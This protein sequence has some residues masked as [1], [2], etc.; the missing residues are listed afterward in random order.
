MGFLSD[1]LGIDDAKDSL[2]DAN[3][4]ARDA[5]DKGIS[6]ADAATQQYGQQSLDYLKPAIQGG[7]DALS[8]IRAA[9]GL[10]GI[11]AQKAFYT[12]FQTDPGF[13]AT[14]QAGINAIQRSRAASGNLNSG[15]TMKSLFNFGQRSLSDQFRQRLQ[16]LNGISTQG[17]AARTNSANITGDMGRTFAD[18]RM[19]RGQ[20]YGDS[21]LQEGKIR[22]DASVAVPNFVTGTLGDLA[23][24][25][26]AV[27]T[28]MP[29]KKGA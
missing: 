16:D 17:A 15:G 10:D 20:L 3:I 27:Y 19:K 28:G 8:R 12:N 18:L 1:L 6:Q 23:K 7:D 5:A 21:Y 22:S 25:A 24:T 26:A 14:Q 9:L 29:P 4:K 11:D 2:L 13:E